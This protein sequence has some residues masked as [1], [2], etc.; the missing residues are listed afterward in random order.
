MHSSVDTTCVRN[1]SSTKYSKL[2]LRYLL[3]VVIVELLALIEYFLWG[4]GGEGGE[5]WAGT[6]EKHS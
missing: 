2:S 3:H 5:G 6:R 4:G 1:H